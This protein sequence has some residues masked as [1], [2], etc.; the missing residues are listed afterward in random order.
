MKVK[1]LP[2]PTLFQMI[3][4]P[5]I[6][7]KSSAFWN[8]EYPL[9]LIRQYGNLIYVKS[10]NQIIVADPFAIEHI[11]KANAKNYH[12][13]PHFYTKKMQLIFGKSLLSLEGHDWK[14]SRKRILPAYNHTALKVYALTITE[15]TQKQLAIW[16]QK[17]PKKLNILTEMGLLSL[18]IAFKIFS[19]CEFTDAELKNLGFSIQF[20]ML[21]IT[22]TAFIHPWLPTF[23]NI[24][25]FWHMR[26]IDDFI[27][28][29]IQQRRREPVLQDDLLNLLLNTT[30]DTETPLSD[31]EILAEFKSHVIPG[32]ETTACCL[33]W[34]WYLLARHPQYRTQM[35]TELTHVLNGAL[36][37]PE[38][39]QQLPVTKAII[40]ETLRLYPPIWCAP[41]TNMAPDVIAG[42][43]IPAHSN[44]NLQLYALHRNPNYWEHP[45]DFMPERFLN[46]TLERHS[47]SFLPFMAGA[48]TCVASHLGML[49]AMLITTQLA[50]SLHF[51]LP[52]KFKVVPEPGISLRPKGGIMMR[53]RQRLKA[54]PHPS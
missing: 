11:L 3:K 50:Q 4:H 29:I 32:H 19:N 20:C 52:R 37:T 26:K 46:P 10:F 47:F 36:P 28:K 33:S 13:N 43:E 15:Q 27:L 14:K 38:A 5:E 21:Y 17:C 40:L 49:E 9:E 7:S 41:R 25:F 16:T 30:G 6:R 2:G 34:M 31:L 42:Y 51:E 8:L 22:K 35:E 39:I 45:N 1:R 48:H 44:L 23:Q 24:R 54:P 53:P 18:R 12:R